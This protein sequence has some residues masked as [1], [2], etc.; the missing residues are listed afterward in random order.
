MKKIIAF[1]GSNSSKS[2]NLRLVKYAGSLLNDVEIEVLDLNDFETA[3][4]SIDREQ[5][6]GIPEKAMLF[7]KKMH[8]ADGIICSMAEHNR[9]YTAAFK[10]LMDWCSRVDM[11]IFG[12]RPMLLMSTSP[13]GYGGGNVMAAAESFFPKVGAKVITTFSLPKFKDNFKDGSISNEEF[14]AT[15]TQRCTEFTEA[16]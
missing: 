2:I 14:N 5:E 7:R 9:S 6:S 13:G 11:N 8:D 10:N 4:Y 3:L 16:L 15:L 12:E 1:A